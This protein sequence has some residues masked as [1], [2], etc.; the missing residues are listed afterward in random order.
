[1]DAHQDV[2]APLGENDKNQLHYQS[3]KTA[4]NQNTRT[5]DLRQ[6]KE[7]P[8]SIR[9]SINRARVPSIRDETMLIIGREIA[10]KIRQGG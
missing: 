9:D 1:M 2:T 5:I 7:K 10:G 4:H 8:P 3:N 6:W